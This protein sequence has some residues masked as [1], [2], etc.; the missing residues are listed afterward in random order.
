MLL[1]GACYFSKAQV[2]SNFCRYSVQQTIDSWKVYVKLGP[3]P[4]IEPLGFVLTGRQYRVHRNVGGTTTISAWMTYNS[5]QYVGTT[6][7]GNSITGIE[8]KINGYINTPGNP[9]S[10][11]FFVTNVCP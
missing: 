1:C 5:V 6:G 4:Y 3:G 8:I 10:N 11:T 9:W 2:A 7:F